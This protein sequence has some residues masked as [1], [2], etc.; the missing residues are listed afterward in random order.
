[1]ETKYCCRNESKLMLRAFFARL[2]DVSTVLFRY[3]LLGGDTAA[4]SGLFARLCHAFLV[5]YR[6]KNQIILGRAE[7]CRSLSFGLPL[8][9][10]TRSS[11]GSRPSPLI[12]PRIRAYRLRHRQRSVG[13]ET[14]G[15]QAA[16]SHCASSSTFY[17]RSE[18]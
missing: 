10:T 17:L 11:F 4:P 16:T 5:M 13:G 8:S 15:D 12:R 3:Y 7:H 14:A 6:P 1:M 2:P 18:K 9:C